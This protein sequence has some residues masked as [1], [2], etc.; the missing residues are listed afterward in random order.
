MSESFVGSHKLSQLLIFLVDQALEGCSP[1]EYSIAIDALQRDESFD[2]RIDPLVR[3]HVGRL[4]NK[5]N[6]YRTTV[7]L[8]DPIEIELP[9][10]TYVP[11]IRVRPRPMPPRVP[12][13]AN[14]ARKI[15]VRPFRSLSSAEPDEYFCEGLIEEL[16]HA[17]A[18]IKNLQIIPIEAVQGG[19][20][21]RLDARELYE[22]LGVVVVLDGNVR[23]SAHQLR[24]AAHLTNTA[25]GS[26]IWSEMYERHIDDAFTIQVMVIQEDIAHAIANALCLERDL[27]LLPEQPPPSPAG[28]LKDISGTSQDISLAERNSEWVYTSANST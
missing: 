19:R 26:V 11:R 20:N 23:K 15:A 16:I 18:K 28:N 2:P 14:A 21:A 17:M 25:D 27:T 3:V 4:R 9:P 24:V 6:Q 8:H 10:R 12:D 5:L 1:N 22:K 13:A 7:G